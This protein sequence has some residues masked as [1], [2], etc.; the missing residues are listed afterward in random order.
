MKS[1]GLLFA[2]IV[3]LTLPCVAF[4]A[5]LT[6][7]LSTTDG[8]TN[9]AIQD[10]GA[11]DV[12]NVDSDGNATFNSVR[13]TSTSGN[14]LR[15]QNTLQSGATF[16]V[17]SGTVAGQASVTTLKFADAST[18]TIGVS[19]RHDKVGHWGISNLAASATNTQ[20]TFDVAG[21]NQIGAGSRIKMAFAGT[22]IG[23]CVTGSAARTA[24]TATFQIYKNG[25]D[26]GASSDAVIDGTNTQFVCSTGGTGTFAAGDILDIR[27]TTN[28]GFLPAA[29]TEYTADLYVN[30][31]N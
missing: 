23:I 21:A 22:A 14:L 20:M 30:Y 8:S 10:S 18:T 6:I 5:D 2:R 24:G 28:A 19:L 12:G 11:V 25:A 29:S 9:M 17:S 7:R 13:Q 1:F 31:T 15:N 4:G 27:V 3:F 26:I 16:Y